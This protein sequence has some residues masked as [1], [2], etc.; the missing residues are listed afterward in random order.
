M[1]DT[2]NIQPIEPGASDETPRLERLLTG[3]IDAILGELEGLTIDE[4]KQVEALEKAG[5]GR[6]TL[7]GAITRDITRREAEIPDDSP[8]AKL[9]I[10]SDADYRHMAA[11]DV[12]S[13]SLSKPVLTRDGWVV[14]H[15]SAMPKE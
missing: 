3:N 7:L 2:Q 6:T 1:S 15:P 14:P 8:E 4:L 13:K 10:P 12:D 9:D 5:K 11:I